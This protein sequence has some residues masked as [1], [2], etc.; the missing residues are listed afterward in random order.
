MR[1]LLLCLCVNA[2]VP[3]AARSSIHTRISSDAVAEHCLIVRHGILA[4]RIELTQ[5][6]SLVLDRGAVRLGNPGLRILVGP[7]VWLPLVQR[8][9]PPGLGQLR[10]SPLGG[11]QLLDL[12]MSRSAPLQ[13]WVAL[14]A[15]LEPGSAR[16]GGVVAADSRD[17]RTTRLQL[18]V[19][20]PRWRVGVAAGIQTWPISLPSL[21]AREYCLPYPLPGAGL[22][23]TRQLALWHTARAGTTRAGLYTVQLPHLDMTTG[24]WLYHRIDWRT[25]GG[26]GQLELRLS[27]E[28]GGYQPHAGHFAAACRSLQAALRQ[29]GR[30]GSLRLAGYIDTHEDSAWIEYS[31]RHRLGSGG[32]ILATGLRM[33]AGGDARFSPGAGWER[34]T[35]ARLLRADLQLQL[36][37]G[38]GRYTRRAVVVYGSPRLRLEYR[39][40]MDSH[41][42]GI[43]QRLR[44]VLQR[45]S[46]RLQLELGWNS[47]S[48]GL[49]GEV[50]AMARDT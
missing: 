31:S 27:D 45:P 43:D 47:L 18:A 48:P 34:R 42:P 11:R 12:D 1:I 21:Q 29:H 28:P 49:D 10:P 14:T 46:L 36:Y 26:S 30:A 7:V 41:M 37:S 8:S 5:A 13:D 39:A 22:A 15:R 16:L 23:V 2:V 24:G 44:L 20:C 3:L 6:D 17:Y 35:A 25:E 38:T 9:A 32:W 19:D 33:P 50:T 40:G 4:G